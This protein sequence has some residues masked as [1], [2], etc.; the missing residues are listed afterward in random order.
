M[1]VR[2]EKSQCGDKESEKM[3][4]NKTSSKME[5]YKKQAIKDKTTRKNGNK[6]RIAKQTTIDS[7]FHKQQSG[8]EKDS[9]DA[10]DGKGQK[11]DKDGNMVMVHEK[12]E[13]QSSK[14]IS[15]E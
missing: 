1:E 5:P 14:M 13:C 4:A 9:N 15:L 10:G 6:A 7:M 8:K 11:W 12:D 2:K 3:P